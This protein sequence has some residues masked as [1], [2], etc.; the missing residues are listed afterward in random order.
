MRIPSAKLSPLTSTSCCLFLNRWSRANLRNLTK[1]TDRNH[2]H[3]LCHELLRQGSSTRQTWAGFF[4][5]TL[6]VFGRHITTPHSQHEYTNAETP[7]TDTDTDRH[8]HTT[9]TTHKIHTY[10]HTHT[11][12]HT[13]TFKT[14]HHT[15]P[16]HKQFEGQQDEQQK[17]DTD[18]EVERTMADQASDKQRPASDPDATKD[19]RTTLENGC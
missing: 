5:L 17:Q 16:H 9:H 8:R 7:H 3:T 4:I 13:H 15:T 6:N 10:T 14:P 11:H 18:T 1:H 2:V 19:L 12:T